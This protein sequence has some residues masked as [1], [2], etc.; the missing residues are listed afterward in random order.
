MNI[1]GIRSRVR[2]GPRAVPAADGN[3]YS[4]FAQA[5]QDRADLLEA[6]DQRPAFSQHD[7]ATMRDVLDDVI[8]EVDYK[9]GLPETDYSDED[10]EWMRVRKAG[11]ERLMDRLN[12]L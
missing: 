6:L 9:L 3:F 2:H 8:Q 1:E 11:Y 10:K 7:L 5:L 4:D 12:A